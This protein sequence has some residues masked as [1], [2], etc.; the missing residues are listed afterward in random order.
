MKTLKQF[1]QE[2]IKSTTRKSMMHLEKAKPSE[3]LELAREILKNGGTL[4]NLKVSLK[5][6]GAGIRFGKDAS[7]NFFFETSRS[8]IIQTP[9]AFSKHASQRPGADVNR[10]KHYDDLYLHVKNSTLWK[11]LPPDTK[12]VAE[13]LYN[14]MAEMKGDKIRFVSVE[15]DKKKLG[16]LLTVIPF[17][18]IIASSGLQHPDKEKILQNLV[19]KSDSKIK[20][21][22][23]NLHS[24]DM[25]VS[26]IL[27]PIKTLEDAE[28][29]LSSRKSA[30]SKQKTLYQDAIQK[31]KD[32]LAAF[33]LRTDA[34]RGKDL[35]GPD[36]EGL[37][38]DMGTRVFKVTTQA[39]KD[40][41]K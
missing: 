40:S 32:E 21:V 37:V 25:D 24:S 14:P 17:D 13:V 9:G 11:D 3:F 31:I 7:G 8:G 27:E 36:I 6:D 12:V 34:I 15:Y 22:T 18:V 33:I 20:V 16:S 19:K 10:A 1:L 38:L 26:V 35:F 39:F 30:D 5:V 23:A 29:I 41:K 4:K 28:R 2:N